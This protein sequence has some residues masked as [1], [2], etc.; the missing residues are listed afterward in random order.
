MAIDAQKEVVPELPKGTDMLLGVDVPAILENPLVKKYSDEIIENAPMASIPGTDALDTDIVEKFDRALTKTGLTRADFKDIF[1]AVDMG[2]ATEEMDPPL[3]VGFIFTKASLAQI[4][5]IH[6]ELSKN[7]TLEDVSVAGLKGIKVIKSGTKDNNAPVIAQYN[8]GKILVIASEKDLV[9]F[10]KMP[11]MNSDAPVA[12]LFPKLDKALF[13]YAMVPPPSK[14]KMKEDAPKT[15]VGIM[16]TKDDGLLGM[17]TYVY[18]NDSEAKQAY[19]AFQA[20]YAQLSM[21]FQMQAPDL[22]AAVK[23]ALKVDLNKDKINGSLV[24]TPALVECIKKFAEQQKAMS[25]Q[26]GGNIGG[27]QVEVEE[28]GVIKDEDVK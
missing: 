8:A 4:K 25:Q 1:V 27:V 14:I 15:Y 23:N 17:L 13:S 3:V 9:K 26:E 18:A 6:A 7:E 22:V 11:K 19:D 16:K 28:D 5:T 21:V 20:Q 10:M 2:D 12:K 24:I